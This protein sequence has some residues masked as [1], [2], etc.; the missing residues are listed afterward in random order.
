MVLNI[1]LSAGAANESFGDTCFGACRDAQTGFN[2]TRA[3]LG[4]LELMDSEGKL[5]AKSKIPEF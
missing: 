3:D 2:I 4:I 5:I 1:I